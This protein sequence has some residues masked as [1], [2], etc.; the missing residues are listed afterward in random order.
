MRKTAIA[1]V[2]LAISGPLA[3]AQDVKPVWVQHLNGL[4]NVDPAS[5]NPIVKANP[6][7][8]YS[9]NGI[10]R[11]QQFSLMKMRRYDDKRFL[12]GV[13]EN[14]VDEADPNLT[15]EAKALA[16][17]FPDRSVVWVS[18][19]DGKPLGLAHTFG[20]RPI[21]ATGQANNNDFFSNWDI[22]DGP[23]GQ[24]A[25]YST[26]KNAILRWAPKTGGGWEAAPS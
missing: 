17:A 20:L 8:R 21:T 11:S 7:A 14:G 16:E 5:Q 6:G 22:D 26:H 1:G 24:R 4:V 12:L 10:G 25:L 23:D 3:L 2:L 13:R 18:A 19:T 9:A 15:P